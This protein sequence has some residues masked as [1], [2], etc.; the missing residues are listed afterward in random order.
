VGLR[1]QE[2]F[3][4]M[5]SLSGLM[6]IRRYSAQQSHISLPEVI[7]TLR[8]ISPDDAYHDYDVAVLLD[9]LIE[10]KSVHFEDDTAF[11]R[12]ALTALIRET[13][14]WWLKLSPFGRERVRTALSSNE[15]QCFE[16]AGLFSESPSRETRQ[17]WDAL[18]QS[19]RSADDAK[20]LEQGRRAEEL[21]IN[22]ENER[23]S[24]I[25]ISNRARWVALD[26]NSAGYD[27]QSFD[28]GVVE[29]IAKLIEV[30]SSA[31]QPREI[32]LTRNEWVSAVERAPHYFFHIWLFPEEH[33][34]ELRPD[35]IKA[36]IPEDR[37]S[38]EWQIAK[39]TLKTSS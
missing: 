27:V 11:F 39:F 12:D 36:N 24:S 15:V 21:T 32:F 17:W 7:S 33:L 38:G 13:R 23:L 8:R 6:A 31:R 5:S 34:I 2:S 26:D 28:A 3:L 1:W 10:K 19:V 37:G 25:G 4:S 18:S 22:Y 14:P 16:A 29:P 35:D 9:S 20:K 30:K